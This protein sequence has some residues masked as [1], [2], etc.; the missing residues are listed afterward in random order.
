M[1]GTKLAGISSLART[2]SAAH[3]ALHRGSETETNG[4]AIDDGD[5]QVA[6]NGHDQQHPGLP[7]Y[8]IHE[9]RTPL[10]SIHGYA[11]VLQRSLRDNP[12]A[13]NALGVVVRET[14]RLSAMLASLSE[15]AELQSGEEFAPSEDVDVYHLVDDAI[16]E[17]ER[18]DGSIHPID[19]AGEGLARCNKS[20]LSQA[21]LHVLANATL[22][23]PGGGPISID[24]GP[25]GCDIAVTISDHGIG[26][27]P[28]DDE[29]IYGP[30]ERGSN[31]RQNGCRGLGLG[32]YLAREA[33]TRTGGQIDHWATD[34]GGTTFRLRVPRA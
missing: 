17:I 6:T 3:D 19:L 15:L 5:R 25:N 2:D 12:R 34:G 16:H 20:L 1:S 29:R 28:G 24:V 27:P 7:S 22:F 9:L 33:L 11:Q 32:L 21:V 18:R 10:T 23:S 30:F 4:S 31:A 13:T 8:V 14:T 26:V